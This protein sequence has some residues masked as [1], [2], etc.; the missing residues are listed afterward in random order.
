[1]DISTAP[2]SAHEL[3]P[4]TWSQA[5]A[6]IV[7][8][9]VMGSA[10]L[11][12]GVSG[13]TVALVLG[14]Y[15]RLVAS[16]RQG[17]RALA[18]LLRGDVSGAIDGLKRVEWA[19]LVPL[20]GGILIAIATLAGILHTLL[21]DEPVAMSAAFFGLVVGSIVVAADLVERRDA[22][23]IGVG[24]VTAVA[25]FFLLGLRSGGITDPALPIFFIA[26]ALAIVAMILPG[27][28]GSFILLMLGMYEPVI[29]A[30]D[31]REIA[32][33]LVV[34]AGAGIG[35]GGFSTVLTW[36][37]DHHRDVVMASLTGLMLGS[38]RVLWPWPAGEDGVGDVALGA[39]VSSE[40]ALAVGL[41]FAGVAVTILG[42]RLAARREG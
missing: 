1:M 22:M 34:G 14:I 31:E 11:V 39:P 21:E 10:D 4:A 19:F 37:L 17:A 9:F 41:A 32:T 18:T 2:P 28:S 25:A 36:L 15:E 30:V 26:G 12:P 7:S 8:G 3:T 35:L 20:L 33:I 23:T 6:T 42:A 29:A 27:I 40:I 13:G 24:A 38:L 5:P 16:I